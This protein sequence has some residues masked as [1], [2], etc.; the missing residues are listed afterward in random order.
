MSVA[1]TMTL[2]MQIGSRVDDC[3]EIFEG[4]CQTAA[5]I[6]VVGLSTTPITT[7]P[8]R[9]SMIFNEVFPA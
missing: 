7:I 1:I 9:L 2:T 4:P 3:V 5:I 6:I 8:E